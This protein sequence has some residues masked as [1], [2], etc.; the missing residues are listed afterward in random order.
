MSIRKRY[1]V[2]CWVLAS[3]V[4]LA[5]CGV[6][7]YH[8]EWWFPALAY[9]KPHKAPALTRVED[10]G[11]RYTW[12]LDELTAA[13]GVTLSNVMLLVNADHPLPEG[14]EPDLVEYNGAKMHPLMLD[15][16][17]RM[18]DDVQKQTGV[19]IYVASDYRTPEEQ[20][21]IINSAE[22]GIAAPLGCSEHEAGLAL[23]LYAPYFDGID[24]LRSRAGRAVNRACAE[25]GY[26][27]RYPVD[28]TNV[29][30]IAYEPWHVR[31]VGAPHAN[32]IMESGLAYEEY[33][34]YL[35]P[36][37]WFR[38]GSYLIARLA[39]EALELPTGWTTCSLSPDNTG[40]YVVTL[41]LA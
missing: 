14:Y 16:Y 36:G 29:T 34:E 38:T 18:R 2:L 12:T 10:V 6:V 1:R 28:K 3:V 9:L 32:I 30:G 41:Q 26:I 40:Y 7:A 33:L 13:E 39:P 27:I 35:T 19:R 22:E 31:Y 15:G 21:A 23:D 4:L 20:S 37:V 8:G 25:Y 24:F 17:I 5:A 11:E